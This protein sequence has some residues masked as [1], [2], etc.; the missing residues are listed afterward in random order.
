MNQKSEKKAN[1]QSDVAPQ[2]ITRRRFGKY[3]TVGA[4][5]TAVGFVI[6]FMRRRYRAYPV[7]T[8]AHAGEIPVGGS[9]I[10]AYPQDDRPCFLL[11]PAE[12]TY[13]AFSRL[14]T[15]HGC[16][17]S[18]HSQE[19][20]F[21]CPCHGGIFSATNGAVLDGPPPT[22]LPQVILERHGDAIVAVGFKE[23]LKATEPK[24]L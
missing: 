15:H 6:A 13:V 14:C 17:V 2:P 24:E 23:D 16:P 9:K 8:V 20:I 1:F 21:T 3:L 10:F 19:S 11:R 5:I 4:A 18:Y 22:P 7:V 12:D